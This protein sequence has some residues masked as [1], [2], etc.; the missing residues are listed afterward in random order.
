LK[1]GLSEYPL[2]VFK[3][4]DLFTT[5]TRFYTVYIYRVGGN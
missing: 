4:G 2:L 3:N 5:N 1:R